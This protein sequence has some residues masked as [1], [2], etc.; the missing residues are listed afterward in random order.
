M[1][2]RGPTLK[3]IADAAASD[4]PHYFDDPRMDDLLALLLE[5]AEENCVLQDR[6]KSA[7]QIAPGTSKKNRRIRPFKRRS[8]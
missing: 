3:S 5:I 7:E 4:R 6:L 1:S 2:D 8:C